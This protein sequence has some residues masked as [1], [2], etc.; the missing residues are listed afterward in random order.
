MVTTVATQSMSLEEKIALGKELMS[1]QE[2]GNGV[3]D[4][5]GEMLRAGER[6]AV[7]GDGCTGT[8]EVSVDSL[9]IPSVWYEGYR[10]YFR[11]REGKVV[12]EVPRCYADGSVET[13]KHNIVGLMRFK[14][15]INEE[16][17]E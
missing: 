11:T 6:Y 16:R 5:N 2:S 15:V 17:E 7:I 4:S 14:R 9:N 10:G 3:K 8:Y 12:L 13:T 1:E